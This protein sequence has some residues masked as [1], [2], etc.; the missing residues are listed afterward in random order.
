MLRFLGLATSVVVGGLC[1]VVLFVV[2]L[3]ASFD[4]VVTDSGGPAGGG[5]VITGASAS[6]TQIAT[7]AQVLEEERVY[8]LM[9]N[10]YSISHDPIMQS[11]YQFWVDSCGFN[12]V[13]CDVAVSGN[14][15]CVEFVT[16]A[17][18]LGG[19][20][21][22]YVGDAITFWPNY[23]HQPGWVRIATTNG[24]PQPGDMVIWQGG[25]FGHI[26]IV[27]AVE[28]PTS[29]HAG[30]VTVAQGNGQGNRWDAAHLQNSGNWYTMS[31]HQDGTLETWPGYQVLGYIRHQ[32]A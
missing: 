32:G 27:M 30:S 1:V 26:A 25:H 5:S 31:L 21:L 17:F 23:A 14:L 24:Y 13:I 4:A 16:G 9:S 20:R 2:V 22:P 3:L 18:Y 10:E 11:V 29:G 6:G 28:K 19:M 7:S 15:Q 8:G 12:G